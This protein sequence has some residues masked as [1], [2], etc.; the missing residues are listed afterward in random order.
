MLAVLCS[1]FMSAELH[2]AFVKLFLV[3]HLSVMFAVLCSTFL[4]LTFLCSTLVM[5]ASLCSAFVCYVVSCSLLNL[6]QVTLCAQPLSVVCLLCSKLFF[7]KPLSSNVLC[8][9][10]VVCLLCN[11]LFFVKPLSSNAL[12][13]T[14]VCVHCAADVAVDPPAERRVPS[15]ASDAN[16]SMDSFE[17]SYVS[18]RGEVVVLGDDADLLES[19]H[20]NVDSDQDDF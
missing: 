16:Y 6:C 3:L 7:V 19:P 20:V 4:M 8:S 5:L 18:E 9:T 12:C 11:K 17:Q 1:A 2:S 13:S 14:F 10:F 15:R